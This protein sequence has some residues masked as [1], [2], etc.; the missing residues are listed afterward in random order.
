MS[1][2]PK[3]KISKNYCFKI[4]IKGLRVKC[5]FHSCSILI[6]FKNRTTTAESRQKSYVAYGMAVGAAA[7]GVGCRSPAAAAAV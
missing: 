6:T 2:V 4:S 7:M 3:L 1:W 5:S